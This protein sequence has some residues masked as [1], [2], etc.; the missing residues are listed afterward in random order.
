MVEFTIFLNWRIVDLKCVNY[1]CKAKQFSVIYSYIY[2]YMHACVYNVHILYIWIYIYIHLKIFFSTMVFY[3]RIL[4]IVLCVIQEDIVVYP[5]IYKSLYQLIPT[6]IALSPHPGHTVTTSL[7]SMSVILL[8][9]HLC[10]ILDSTC[11]WY[12]VFVFLFSNLVWHSLVAAILL[13][14]ALFCSFLWQSS[15]PLYIWIISS[16]SIHL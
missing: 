9:V 11:K 14:M 6:S 1:Y 3:H 12:M 10:D 4:N 7:L 8:L 2:T 16:L 15:I 5:H 13:H